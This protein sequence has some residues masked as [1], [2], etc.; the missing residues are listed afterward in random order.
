MCGVQPLPLWPSFGGVLGETAGLP[1]S[2]SRTECS[3]TLGVARL[4]AV[5]AAAM[6]KSALPSRSRCST[7][8]KSP[9]VTQSRRPLACSEPSP[10]K[11]PTSSASSAVISRGTVDV[12]LARPVA[13]FGQRRQRHGLRLADQLAE[14]QRHHV[15]GAQVGEA[16]PFPLPGFGRRP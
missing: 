8:S 2:A 9:S 1:P 10:M 14:R 12:V 15:A 16:P 3:S 13:A 4:R 7:T 6:P 5:T 11:Y